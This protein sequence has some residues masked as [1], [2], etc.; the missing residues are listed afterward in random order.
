MLPEMNRKIVFGLCGS[1]ESQRF[2]LILSDYSPLPLDGLS[3]LEIARQIL[4]GNDAV[5]VASKAAQAPR[6]RVVSG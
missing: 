3:A 6:H 4:P 5:D 2:D 1:L